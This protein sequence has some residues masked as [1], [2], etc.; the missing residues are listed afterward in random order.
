MEKINI[1]HYR[2]LCVWLLTIVFLSACAHTESKSIQVEPTTVE[3]KAV[4]G[5]ESRFNKSHEPLEL[6]AFRDKSNGIKKMATQADN[7]T[8]Q[9]VVRSGDNPPAPV[10]KEDR[11]KAASQAFKAQAKAHPPYKGLD[12]LNDE[13]NE[14]ILKKSLPMIGQYGNVDSTGLGHYPR[15]EGERYQS[16][17]PII[18]YVDE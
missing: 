7:V 2:R 15:R 12:V 11:V 17:K 4:S 10:I 13:E 1:K 8:A 3:K 18:Y 14:K 16:D 5:V 9:G 6:Q